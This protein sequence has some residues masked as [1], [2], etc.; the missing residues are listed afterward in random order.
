MA[1][2]FRG[3]A[4]ERASRRKPGIPAKLGFACVGLLAGIVL[5]V[6]GTLLF[7]N[8]NTSGEG[9]ESP[10][11]VFERIVSQ[12]EMV[13]VSQ[14]Y[15]I[16]EVVEDTNE[17]LGFSIPGTKNSFW[18]RYVGT[19]KAGANLETAKMT[20]SGRTITI[21]LRQPYIISNTPDSEETGVLEER[22][23]ILNPIHVE[24]VDAFMAECRERSQA[25][26]IEG[27]LLDRAREGVEENLR[28]MFFAALGDAYDIRFVWEDGFEL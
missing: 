9:S 5:G 13:S 16:V 22:N 8:Y 25:E 2:I 7:Q 23:N 14:D 11:T 15:S 6:V 21:S 19:L 26:A 28:T 17:I 4:A 1:G 12:N 27:G 3:R 18:F 24:D 10:E 20:V